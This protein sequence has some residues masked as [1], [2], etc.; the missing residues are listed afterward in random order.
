[1][2]YSLLSLAPAFYR[3][4]GSVQEESTA[5]GWRPG[6][7]V[8][9]NSVINNYYLFTSP[10]QEY[11]FV[12][13]RSSATSAILVAICVDGQ[14]PSL[15]LWLLVSSEDPGDV[16]GLLPTSGHVPSV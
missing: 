8:H 6:S 4:P 11:S 5:G 13:R 15:L 3:L 16:P 9:H 7:G 12:H 14:V 1:M 2:Q 10:I